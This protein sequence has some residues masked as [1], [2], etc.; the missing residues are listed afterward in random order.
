MCV[1]LTV[2]YKVSPYH[3][4]T[5]ATRLKNSTINITIHTSCLDEHISLLIHTDIMDIQ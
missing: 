5:V 3:V 4:G 1:N 2:K